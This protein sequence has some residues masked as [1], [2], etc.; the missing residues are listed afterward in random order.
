MTATAEDRRIVWRCLG[1][2][3]GPKKFTALIN[4]IAAE[5]HAYFEEYVYRW[6]VS[7]SLRLQG[8]GKYLTSPMLDLLKPKEDFDVDEVIEHVISRAGGEG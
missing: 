3:A 6:Y 1:I 7:E 8:E 5:R 4:F 2:Y